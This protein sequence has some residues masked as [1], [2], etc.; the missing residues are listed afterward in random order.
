YRVRALSRDARV[1]N[2]YGYTGGFSVNA[3]LGGARA[4]TTVDVA[5]GAIAL[6]GETF[7]ANGLPAATHEGVVSDVPRFLEEAGARTWDLIVS[8]PPSFAP[9]AKALDAA[10]A[11]YTALHA[12]CLPRL[13][14]GGLYLAASCSS[15]VDAARFEE[16][17]REGARRAGVV[18]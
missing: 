4:V 13:P 14:L 8:D 6:S 12:A 10:L 2:L 5:S 7:E 17:L 3:A 1:L 9:S 11:S 18:L 16:T 15:H